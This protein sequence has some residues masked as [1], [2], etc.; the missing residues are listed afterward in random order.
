MMRSMESELADDPRQTRT[1][2]L[3]VGGLSLV[4]GAL[5][6]WAI[7]ATAAGGGFSGEPALW[8]YLVF[9]AA[10]SLAAGFLWWHRTHPLR[11]FAAVLLVFAL[12][13]LL[14]GHTGNAGMTLPLW[15]SV[16]AVAAHA[17]QRAGL[18]LVGT[19]WLVSAALRIGTAVADG[20]LAEYPPGA[21]LPAIGLS[22]LDPGFFFL[23]CFALGTGFRL[24]RQRAR[25]AA[26]RARLL[27]EQARLV[28]DRAH[29][30]NAEAVARERNRMARELHDLAAHELMDVLLSVRALRITSDDP[31]LSEVEEKTARALNDMR[32]VVRTLREDDSETPEHAPLEETAQRLIETLTAERGLHV[33]TRLHLAAP[34]P[35]AAAQ[36]VLSVL[37]ET[38][39]N[40]HAHAPGQPLTVVLETLP[41]SAAEG[42]RARGRDAAPVDREE[43]PGRTVP[44]ASG[45]GT[46]TGNTLRLTVSNPLGP[47]AHATGTTGTGYGLVGAVE[48]AA[49]LDGSFR[50][51]PDGQGRWT[52]TLLLPVPTEAAVGAETGRPA[53]VP[54]D[55]AHSPATPTASPTLL[56]VQEDS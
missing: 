18:A 21:L 30:R 16:Y 52:A 47:T 54:P 35:P 41:P 14:A 3:V 53:S 44:E 26:E 11:V 24:Q 43:A 20:R 46:G 23:T 6:V 49:L 29:A 36:A 2:V 40:A 9:V 8:T 13:S 17:P 38:L 7:T 19:G 48:R 45:T 51:G 32:T 31:V 27:E 4:T 1:V 34:V 28:E 39:L 56:T 5:F 42:D 37:K 12:S 22:A 15:F 50:A 10:N 33:D 25:D 55:S